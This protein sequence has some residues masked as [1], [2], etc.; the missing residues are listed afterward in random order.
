MIHLHF[1]RMNQMSSQPPKHGWFQIVERTSS[2]WVQKDITRMGLYILQV[3]T[4]YIY[5]YIHCIPCFVINVPFQM[6]IQCRKQSQVGGHPRWNSSQIVDALIWTAPSRRKSSMTADP[7]M[8]WSTKIM[9]RFHLLSSSEG[10]LAEIYRFGASDG[11]I[12]QADL[13]TWISRPGGKK[14]MKKKNYLRVPAALVNFLNG[15]H[16][17]SYGNMGARMCMVAELMKSIIECMN[18]W[19]LENSDFTFRWLFT[20]WDYKLQNSIE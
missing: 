5:I 16:N 8:T 19:I 20:A 2:L 3:G 12:W 17:L 4:L 13:K 11:K 10:I 6:S 15:G 14:K 18:E 7:S 9:A 1:P